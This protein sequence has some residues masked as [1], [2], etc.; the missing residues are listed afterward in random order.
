MIINN[1]CMKNE[2]N[3]KKRRTEE[4]DLTLIG[5]DNLYESYTVK[6]SLILAL[7][8]QRK[9]KRDREEVL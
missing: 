3:K 1:L 6:H 8:Y 2:S 5:E 4:H 9:K 7:G